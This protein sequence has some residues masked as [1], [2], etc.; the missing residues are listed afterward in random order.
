MLIILR[1]SYTF[2]IRCIMHYVYDEINVLTT[3]YPRII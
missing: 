3:H 2:M 1:L